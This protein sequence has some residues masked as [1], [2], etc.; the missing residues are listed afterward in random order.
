MINLNEIRNQ[1]GRPLTEPE[2]RHITWINGW[3]SEAQNSFIGL[4]KAA[5]WN[6]A[7]KSGETAKEPS[8]SGMSEQDIEQFA[9]ALAERYLQVTR[10][11]SEASIKYV[12]DFH[13]E[14]LQAD[15][16]QKSFLDQE[17]KY[18]QLQLFSDV[19][20]TLPSDILTAFHKTHE[21]LTNGMV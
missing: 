8:G 19:I 15:D 2:Q 17:K 11:Y 4:I 13:A 6:G 1:V 9:T 18:S 21:R 3:D 7:K 12:R 5:Y 20:S 16:L 14:P 10:E